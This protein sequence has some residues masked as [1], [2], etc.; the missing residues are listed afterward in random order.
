MKNV[1][2]VLLSYL[3][4]NIAVA[5]SD[6]TNKRALMKENAR[7]LELLDEQFADLISLRDSCGKTIALL[8]Q[9]VPKLA[10]EYN[11]LDTLNYRSLVYE[12]KLASIGI[13]SVQ[14]E[15]EIMTELIHDNLFIDWEFSKKKEVYNR[16]L[17]LRKNFEP[18][19][20]W[21]AS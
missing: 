14:K 6:H 3:L 4:F 16:F 20:R 19:S 1:C 15:G 9:L 5:Q 17:N 13:Y 2:L 10:H 18:P 7:L 11:Q 12:E 21:S 8:D